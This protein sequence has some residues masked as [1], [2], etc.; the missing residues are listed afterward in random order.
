LEP[1][2]LLIADMQP[3]LRRMLARIARD[4]ARFEIVAQVESPRGLVAVAGETHAHA[5]IVGEDAAYEAPLAALRASRPGLRVLQVVGDGAH[6]VLTELRPHRNVYGNVSLETLL[7]A[8]V[9]G[10]DRWTSSTQRS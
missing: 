7:A 2:R 4:D 9:T 8:L 10:D 5:V 3:L 1:I 6:A